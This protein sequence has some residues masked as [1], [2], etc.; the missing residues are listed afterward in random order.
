V[1]SGAG[2]VAPPS[3]GSIFAYL[4]VIPPGQHFQVLT[5][6]FIGALA[7]FLVGVFILRI[8]PVKDTVEEETTATVGSVPGLG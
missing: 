2:L 1:V 6:V 4:A 7:S 3:P 5:G 8:N